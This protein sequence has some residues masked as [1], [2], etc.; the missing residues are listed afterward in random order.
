VRKR[1][2]SLMLI[3]LLCRPI[4]AGQLM[5]A[6]SFVSFEDVKLRRALN[7]PD[8][9]LSQGMDALQLS[10]GWTD[11]WTDRVQYSATLALLDFKANDAGAALKWTK[12]SVGLDYSFNPFSFVTPYLGAVIN[13]NQFNE[14]FDSPVWG[15]GV[16]AGFLFRVLKSSFMFVEVDRDILYDDKNKTNMNTAYLSGGIRLDLKDLFPT[17]QVPYNQKK[18]LSPRLK[19]RVIKQYNM[20]EKP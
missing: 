13:W 17:V 15:Y 7:I 1:L 11:T 3:C 9:F 2:F 5:L 12:L 16:R 8:G 14:L 19:N 20:G 18:V 6:P 4:S 10:L